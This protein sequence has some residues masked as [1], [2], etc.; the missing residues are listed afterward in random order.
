MI[1]LRLFILTIFITLWFP[2][3]VSGQNIF[4]KQSNESGIYKKGEKIE[5]KLFVKI[6]GKDSMA[7]KIL[8]I[9][10][11]QVIQRNVKFQGDTM[12]IY[13]TILDGPA[14]LIF[15]AKT[16]TEFASIGAIAEPAK[17][18]PGI[19]PPDDFDRF[20]KEEKKAL[21]ALPVK[22]KMVPVKVTEPGYSCSDMEINCTGPKP[23]R[24]YFAK[25]VSAKPK[26]LPIVLYV[27]AAGVKGAWCRSEPENALRYAKMGKG[28]LCFDLNAHGMLNGQ[29]DEYYS[30]LEIGELKNYFQQGLESRSDCYFRGMYLRLI[31]TLDFLES[32]P[33]WD[34]KRILVLGESQGG[35]Q[36]LAAAG[37][38]HR[39]SAVVATVPAMCDL[40]G[41]M[42]GRKETFPYPF[43][44][45]NNKE[46][47]L[48]TVPYFDVAHLLR[49]SKATLVVEIGLIDETC[50]ATS[51][52]AAINQAKGKEIVY[53]VPYRG[54][55]VEQPAYQKIWESTVYKPKEDFIR[56]YLK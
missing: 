9:D 30:N 27:H 21:R 35:G 8:K 50:P 55:H 39:V 38:D 1:T 16:K 40:G 10:N 32:Q 29:P 24:G 4:L 54:H 13:Q 46:K 49:R 17:Y 2:A 6:P 14:S 25:P 28:A 3:F 44:T 36:A 56:D 33:E 51:I 20:W 37:L 12:V 15:E 31:R 47:M 19:R 42:A 48:A 34:G 7:I 43:S 11:G 45:K 18:S 22:V 23:A 5:V 26:S 53:A 52:Y 41:K